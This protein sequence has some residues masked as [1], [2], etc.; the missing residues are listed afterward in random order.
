MFTLYK[1][2]LY[3][4]FLTVAVKVGQKKDKIDNM[5]IKLK[6]LT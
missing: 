1:I 6:L 4:Q 3:L 2:I 5:K